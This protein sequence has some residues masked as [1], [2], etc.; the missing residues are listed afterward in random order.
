[1]ASSFSSSSSSSLGLFADVS[2]L[3]D[4]ISPRSIETQKNQ[5][6]ERVKKGHLVIKKS[7]VN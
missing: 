5:K 3:Y 6:M 2:G 1:M 7:V 4:N